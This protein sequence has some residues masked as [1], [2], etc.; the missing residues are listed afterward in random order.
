[1]IV[2]LTIVRLYLILVLVLIW[3]SLIISDIENFFHMPV[4][5]PYDFFGEMSIEVFCLFFNLGC[6]FVCLFFAVELYEL[7]VYFGD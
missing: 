2:I 7:F 4:G 6:L 3:I 1:M 5:H